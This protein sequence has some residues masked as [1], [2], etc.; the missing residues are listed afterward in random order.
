MRPASIVNFERLYLGAI[1]LGILHL[2]LTWEQTVQKL[3]ADPATQGAGSGLL[4]I[5]AGI[6]IIIPL[7]LWYFVARK[8]SIVAKWI[9][10]AFFAFGVAGFFYTVS[11]TGFPSGVDG[12]MTII[13]MALQVGAIYMLFR[14]DSKAWFA[15]GRGGPETSH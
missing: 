13:G 8:G 14:P 15:D 2:F 3:N 10:V 4:Y 7:L 1:V 6:G 9:L 11:S 5:S 12:I